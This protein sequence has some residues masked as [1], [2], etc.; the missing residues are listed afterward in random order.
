MATNCPHCT[1]E[2]IQRTAPGALI[3]SYRCKSCSGT[4]ER[5]SPTAKQMAFIGALTLFTGG[6]D[7]GALGTAIASFFGGSDNS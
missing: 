5:M 3:D 1:S 7:G 4:F 6:L 2:N